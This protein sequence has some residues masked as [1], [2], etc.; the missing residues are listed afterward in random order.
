[1][2]ADLASHSVQITSSTPPEALAAALAA[3]GYAPA[4]A[5]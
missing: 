5:T 3:A 1:V 2:Q 4:P